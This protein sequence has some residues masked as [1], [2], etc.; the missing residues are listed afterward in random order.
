VQD[1]LLVNLMRMGD[2]L[3]MT[4][5]IQGL[6]EMHP[7][8]R[9]SMVLNDAFVEV[10]QRIDVDRIV[11]LPVR[12]FIDIVSQKGNLPQAHTWLKDFVHG[13]NAEGAFDLVFNLTPSQSAASLA[14]LIDHHARRGMWLGED[15][16]FQAVDPW[17]AYL[18][19]MM[20][21][22]KTNPFHLVDI[23]LRTL[24]QRG[25]R[26]L[27]IS[28]S[29]EDVHGTDQL[30]SQ[31]G[32][33]LDRDLLVGFQVSASQKE[34][35]WSKKE[36][37]RLGQA[38]QQGLNARVLL[39]G[40]AGEET[41]CQEVC[42][43]IPGSVNLAGKTDIGQLAGV[44]KRCQ[45]LVT[46]DT[47]TQHVATAVDTRVV[48]ISVGPVFFRETGPYGEGHLI[49]QAKL[50][51]APCSFHSACLNPVCKEKIRAQLVYR[52]LV[53]LLRGEDGMPRDLPY[54]VSCY[55]S[56]FDQEGCL[57][58][59]SLNPTFEDRKVQIYKGFWHAL[60][61]GR[62]PDAFQQGAE[63]VDPATLAGWSR[64]EALLRRSSSLIE[65]I[66]EAGMPENMA[67]SSLPVLSGNLKTTEQEMRGLPL[68][69]EELAPITRFLLLRRE[70]LS[71][72]DP[73]RFLEKT[74][75]LYSLAAEHISHTY[76]GL[77]ARKE[78]RC[79]G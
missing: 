20:A 9:I 77:A 57:A 27:Q 58:F 17:A 76:E 46:N 41:L 56:G 40:V 19:A 23:W 25:P 31:R 43:H 62:S 4:P 26:S 75:S 13:V 48:L 6:R 35:C 45:V 1:L 79:Y 30:L 22:R 37:V 8:A 49:F 10:A 50:P 21:H 55:R 16:S 24:A 60:L 32:I 65:Q 36:F 29:P 69:T 14:S 42:N 18:V 70:A 28:L 61:E 34:K 2:I 71:S 59:S 12:S 78:A 7:E 74:S 11:P 66:R 38:L 3:Q 47:G 44:L 63:A 52:T 33:D 54:E 68:D 51:C 39:L 15:G 72:K 53:R 64:L 67:S 5:L 73:M